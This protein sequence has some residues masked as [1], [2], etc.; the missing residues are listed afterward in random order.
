VLVF[1]AAV[2]VQTTSYELPDG[3]L[4]AGVDYVYCVLL[5]DITGAFSENASWAFQNRFAT[6]GR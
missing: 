6:T 1:S 5:G 2:L 4:Q 3:V